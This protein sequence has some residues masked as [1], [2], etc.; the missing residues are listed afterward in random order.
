MRN[1]DGIRPPHTHTH[2]SLSHL[3]IKCQLAPTMDGH[4]T[5]SHGGIVCRCRLLPP[6]PPPSTTHNS[7]LQSSL[8]ASSSILIAILHLKMGTAIRPTDRRRCEVPNAAATLFIT[9]IIIPLLDFS[10]VGLVVAAVRCFFFRKYKKY[11]VS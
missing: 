7:R 9:M 11:C 5:F 8:Y 1:L 2:T 3:Y 4:L 6:P 10:A